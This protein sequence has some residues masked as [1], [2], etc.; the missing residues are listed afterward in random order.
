M[1]E[2]MNLR[3]TVVFGGPSPEHDISILTGLQAARTLTDGGIE[4]QALYWTKTGEW[5]L[6]EPALEAA[7]FVEGPPPKARRVRFQAEAEG[8]FFLRRRRL[9]VPVILNACHG[10]PG[11][12]G[13]LQAAF[14][15][16]GLRYTGPGA[17]ASSLGM[18]KLAF[19]ALMKAF[20][21]PT[22]ERRRVEPDD[23]QPPP[24]ES[25]YVVKPRSGGSSIGIEVVDDFETAR[26]LAETSPHLRDGAVIEPFLVGSRDVNVAVRTHPELEV[27]ALEAPARSEG[28]IYGYVEKYLSGGGLEGSARELPARLPDDVAAWIRA[29]ARRVARLAGLRSVARIDFLVRGSE[30]WVNEVNTIPGSLAAYLWVDPPL[31]RFDLLMG[32]LTEASEEPSRRFTSAG[33]DGTALRSAASIAQKLG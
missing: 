6:I 29:L 24:F 11:E 1:M 25:P 2:R 26:R 32:M 17:A 23:D 20:G 30:V 27:S 19:G 16:A 13:S 22:V 28:A 15:L 12:D 8:G 21:L 9:D 5:Y 31:S 33:A 18:D 7:D 4:T 14:D 3:P 10:G